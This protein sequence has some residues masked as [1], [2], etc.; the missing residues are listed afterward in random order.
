MYLILAVRIR[1]QAETNTLKSNNEHL[2][3]ISFKMLSQCPCYG[4]FSPSTKCCHQVCIP[5]KSSEEWKIWWQALNTCHLFLKSSLYVV[6]QL[7]KNVKMFTV[8]YFSVMVRHNNY[9]INLSP[10]HNIDISYN[11]VIIDSSY[12]NVIIDL[13]Y[14]TWSS[15]PWYFFYLNIATLH[16]SEHHCRGERN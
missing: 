10:Y 6:I 1:F 7:C 2:K 16:I 4:R 11:N 13:L 15:W 8:F 12:N 14:D 3:Q 9:V 5:P